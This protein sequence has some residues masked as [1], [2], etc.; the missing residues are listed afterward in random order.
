DWTWNPDQ[1]ANTV[2]TEYVFVLREADGSMH[3]AH[4][5]HRTGLFE[6]LSRV[7]DEAMKEHQAAALSSVM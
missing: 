2:L 3:V 4:E 6:Q 7:V 1:A 5:T